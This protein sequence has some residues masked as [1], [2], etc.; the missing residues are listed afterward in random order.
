MAFAVGSSQ[1]RSEERVGRR[2]AKEGNRSW[3]KKWTGGRT[4]YPLTGMGGSTL[5]GSAWEED[6]S[7]GGGGERQ[8]VGVED[9]V[10]ADGGESNVAT[11]QIMVVTETIV[12]G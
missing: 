5:G 7:K 11:I 2:D 1:S 6:G 4:L 12:E 3:R 10:R 9:V 8:L